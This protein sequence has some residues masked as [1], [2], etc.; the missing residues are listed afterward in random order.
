MGR[1][2]GDQMVTNG[3][4]RSWASRAAVT[5]KA[6]LSLV[7][8][9]GSGCNLDNRLVQPTD[10]GDDVAGDVGDVVAPPAIVIDTF[11]DLEDPRFQAWQYYAYNTTLGELSSETVTPGYDSNYAIDLV[12]EVVDPPDGAPNYPGVGLRAVPV[13]YLDLSGYSAVVFAQQ[14]VHTGSCQAITTLTVRLAC[15]EYNAAFTASVPISPQWTTSTVTF[16]SFAQS[17][18]P[19]PTP[20]DKG[21]CFKVIDGFDF[22]AQI[23]LVDGDCA[24]GDLTLDNISIR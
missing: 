24:S 12:W 19:S 7:A 15:S 17:A 3:Y 20:V 4:H 1:E 8:F 9:W 22:Q 5:L 13:S 14:Y 21:Q 16:T 18:Y 11:D 23:D 2:H 10:A 6:G